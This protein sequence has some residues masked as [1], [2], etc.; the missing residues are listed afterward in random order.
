M[1]ALACVLLQQCP[2]A[3][4]GSPP[5][6]S[7]SIHAIHPPACTPSSL[8]CH[9]PA[10]QQVDNRHQAEPIISP[11][12]AVKL[13]DRNFGIGGDGVRLPRC[14]AA[15]HAVE[16]L[17]LLG[18][19]AA[20]AA[21]LPASRPLVLTVP[22]PASPLPPSAHRSS[23]HCPL[24]TALTTPCAS[25][26]RTAASPRCAATA[27]AASRAS[28]RVRVAMFCDQSGLYWQWHR[29]CS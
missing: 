21:C 22:S 13:C 16:L 27:S 10:H 17:S 8:C 14:A 6:S 20:A 11:E 1:H 3:L 29:L 24:R 9:P 2:G 15:R 7:P 28:W 4:W 23:L 19:I 5:P 12:Q 18:S 25:S 26:T